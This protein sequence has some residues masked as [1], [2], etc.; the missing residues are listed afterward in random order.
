M[1]PNI[2][3]TTDLQIKLSL[4]A[5][6]YANADEYLCTKYCML[7]A[8]GKGARIQFCFQDRLRSTNRIAKGTITEARRNVLLKLTKP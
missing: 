3:T 4:A 7:K 2:T 5:K 8:L 6:H 1:K